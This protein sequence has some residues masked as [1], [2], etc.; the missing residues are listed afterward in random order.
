MMDTRAVFQRIDETVVALAQT[1]LV[2]VDEGGDPLIVIHRSDLDGE[3]LFA[4]HPP[5]RQVSGIPHNTAGGDLLRDRKSV[6]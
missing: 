1:G 2:V 5:R 4:V 6:V 3:E